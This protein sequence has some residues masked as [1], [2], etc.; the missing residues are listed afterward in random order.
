MCVSMLYPIEEDRNED[1]VQTA[2]SSTE[3]NESEEYGSKNEFQTRLETICTRH[4]KEI[5]EHSPDYTW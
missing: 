4:S 1:S 3:Q 2:E 5:Q